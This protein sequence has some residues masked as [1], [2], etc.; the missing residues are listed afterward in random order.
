MRYRLGQLSTAKK[1]VD[2]ESVW[3]NGRNVEGTGRE[4]GIT[5]TKTGNQDNRIFGPG[6]DTGPFWI[7]LNV[8]HSRFRQ[9]LTQI[10]WQQRDDG[11]KNPN[12]RDPDDIQ[13]NISVSRTD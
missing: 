9:L 6:F 12:P 2:D 13:F 7:S 1:W 4:R 8:K 10:V 5:N 3:W 11:L